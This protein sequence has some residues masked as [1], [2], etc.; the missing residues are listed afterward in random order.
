MVDGLSGQDGVLVP[1]NLHGGSELFVLLPEQGQLLAGHIVRL[2][3]LLHL[4]VLL[5]N[6]VLVLEEIDRLCRL[7]VALLRGGVALLAQQAGYVP[8]N[9]AK[10]LAELVVEEK[11]CSGA[12]PQLGRFQSSDVTLGRTNSQEGKILNSKTHHQRYR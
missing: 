7:P 11:L 3:P 4:D 12:A 9:A 6:E 8:I 10:K 1:E 5:S 2:H